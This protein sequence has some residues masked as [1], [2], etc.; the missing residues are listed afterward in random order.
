MVMYLV[1]GTEQFILF[2][3]HMSYQSHDACVYAAYKEAVPVLN[4]R[5]GG[6]T[7]AFIDC[8]QMPQSRRI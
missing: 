6:L 5:G 1:V 3:S 7:K 2:P 8:V 4:K